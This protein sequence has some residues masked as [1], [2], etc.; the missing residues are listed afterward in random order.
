MKL[1][2]DNYLVKHAVLL[3]VV[4]GNNWAVAFRKLEFDYV[5][6]NVERFL[7]GFTLTHSETVEEVYATLDD[8]A[9][10]VYELEHPKQEDDSDASCGYFISVSQRVGMPAS[11]E[12]IKVGFR[13]GRKTFKELAY[14]YFPIVPL[15]HQPLRFSLIRAVNDIAR[16]SRRSVANVITA[17]KSFFQKYN[18][19]TLFTNW[20]TMHCVIDDTIPCG[21]VVLCIGSTTPR[22]ARLDT[23]FII[24]PNRYAVHP[25]AQAYGVIVNFE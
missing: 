14:E 25:N 19:K 23:A 5:Y 16:R 4:E 11:I 12:V 18:V 21:S 22:T 15:H 8:V 10:R 17:N 24:E 6:Y 9:A 20:K 1:K 3:N 2:F 13:E 7:G